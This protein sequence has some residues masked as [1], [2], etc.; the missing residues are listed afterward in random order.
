MQM[1]FTAEQFFDIFSEYNTATWPAQIIAYV[2]GILACLLAYRESKTSSRIISGIL[3]LSWIW[4]GIVYHIMH[5]AKIN[6][7]ARIFGAFFIVQGLLFLVIGA[8]SGKLSFQ[9][10]LKPLPV[11][12]ACFILYALAIYP[13]LGSLFGHTYPRAPMFGVAPCPATIFTFGMLLWTTRPVPAYLLAIPLLW[14]LIGL[15]AATSLRVPQDYGLVVAGV[16]GTVM[17]LLQNR[18]AARPARDA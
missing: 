8:V 16:L 14:A 2:L 13:V 11:I 4:M 12:G 9:F 5:F 6:P 7:V 18:K 3:A 10:S 15:S 1:P 17:V